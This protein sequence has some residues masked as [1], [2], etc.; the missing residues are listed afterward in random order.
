MV[1]VMACMI[2]AGTQELLILAPIQ[3]TETERQK[4][5]LP[6]PFS[7]LCPLVN[8]HRE[9]WHLLFYSNSTIFSCYRCVRSFHTVANDQVTTSQKRMVEN[10]LFG[11]RNPGHPHIP[12]SALVSLH[13]NADDVAEPSHRRERCH[14]RTL[15]DLQQE[16]LP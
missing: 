2:T 14:R 3:I 6:C 5:L 7:P 13:A 12:P 8:K 10:W 9:I 4:I 15:Q 1:M 11:E 16:P